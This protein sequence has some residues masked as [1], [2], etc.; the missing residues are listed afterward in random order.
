M[1]LTKLKSFSKQCVRVW[2]LLRKP[3][4]DEFKKVSLVAAV[5][6]LAIGL[7]GFSIALLMTYIFPS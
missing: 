3:K 2:H 1:A 5:G 7:I 4:S 6:L